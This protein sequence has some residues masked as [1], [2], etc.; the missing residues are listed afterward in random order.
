MLFILAVTEKSWITL[1]LAFFVSF[2]ALMSWCI[3]YQLLNKNSCPN[4]PPQTDK[5]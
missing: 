3:V 5:K 1:L 4:Q 2:E